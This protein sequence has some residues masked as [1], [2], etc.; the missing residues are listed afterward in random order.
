MMEDN[1][2]TYYITVGSGEITQSATA[3]RWDF[4]ITA[5][6]NEIQQLR[7]YFKQNYS[8]DGRSFWRAHIPFLEYHNDKENDEFDEVMLK[9]YELIY[10]LGDN[11]TRS[12]IE[13]M[14][15]LND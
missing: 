10:R 7:S 14:G 2:Q 15:I 1:R 8:T 13:S 12:H 5:T 9:A 3:A 11:E 6:S 4:K